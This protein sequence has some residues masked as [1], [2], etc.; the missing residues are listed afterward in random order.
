VYVVEK[1]ILCSIFLYFTE[2]IATLV[3]NYR[4]IFLNENPMLGRVMT[5]HIR[6]LGPF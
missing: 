1:N 5:L 2:K 3:H 4:V 6:G